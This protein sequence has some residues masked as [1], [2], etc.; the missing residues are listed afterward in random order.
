MNYTDQNSLDF[1]EKAREYRERINLLISRSNDFKTFYD[2]SEILALDGKVID[3]KDIFP[4]L[5]VHFLLNFDSSSNFL[6]DDLRKLFIE[7]LSL[8][9]I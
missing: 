1:F 3:D 4:N 6:T 9:H 5:I 8:I 2:G 7:E